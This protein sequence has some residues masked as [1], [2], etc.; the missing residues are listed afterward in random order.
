MNVNEQFNDEICRWF[1]IIDDSVGR[2]AFRIL[3]EGERGPPLHKRK[4]INNYE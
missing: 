3:Y 4:E 2:L 1:R